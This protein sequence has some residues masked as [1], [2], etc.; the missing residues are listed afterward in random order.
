ML[1]QRLWFHFD[2]ILRMNSQGLNAINEHRQADKQGLRLNPLKNWLILLF[3]WQLMAARIWSA[4]PENPPGCHPPWRT[5]NKLP[6]SIITVQGKNTFGCK[7]QPTKDQSITLKKGPRREGLDREPCTGQ[8][9]EWG[10]TQPKP[11][12]NYQG[13]SIVT[14]RS[15]GLATTIFSHFSP[16]FHCLV[17]GLA[18]TFVD[19]MNKWMSQ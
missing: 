1:P 18:G 2:T 16:Y 12:E 11:W 5:L 7:M 19:S 3:P 4:S 10:R 6:C 9:V 13:S 14:L 15:M 17:Q 8:A